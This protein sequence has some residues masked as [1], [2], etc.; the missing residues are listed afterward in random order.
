MASVV[1]LPSGLVPLSCVLVALFRLPLSQLACSSVL[2]LSKYLL[3]F[4]VVFT[5]SV[6]GRFCIGFGLTFAGKDSVYSCVVLR[7]TTA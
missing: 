6:F 7:L 4:D 1:A 5:S 3:T 2:G